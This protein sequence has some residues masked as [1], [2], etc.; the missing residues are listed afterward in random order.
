MDAQ[1]GSKLVLEIED[2]S[3]ELSAYDAAAGEILT[4]GTAGANQVCCSGPYISRHHAHIETQR[5]S[6]YLVDASSN[7][8]FVQTEDERVH[9]V[10]RGRLRLWGKGWIA[11]G[12]PL[13]ARRPILFCEN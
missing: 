7:G 12:E 3:Y 13:Q 9:Y 6:F 11:L 8:T 1:P 5:D 4:L 10:H 2:Q